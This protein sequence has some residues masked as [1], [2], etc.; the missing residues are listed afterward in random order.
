MEPSRDDSAPIFVRGFSRS[1]GTLVVTL[2]DAHP[3]IAMSYELYPNL[4]DAEEE[5]LDAGSIARA[6]GRSK[7][8]RDAAKRM[9]T[10]GLR[11]FVT[12][13]A[14]GGLDPSSLSQLL[15]RHRDEG[16]G[17][18]TVEEQLRLIELCCRWKMEIAGKSR[19]GLKCNNRYEEYLRVWPDAF[20][21]NVVRDGRDVLSSQLKTGSFDNSPAAV[22]QGWS[23][24]HQRFKVL[25]ERPD[26][27]AREIRYERLVTEPESETEELCAFLGAPFDP[28][29]LEFHRRDLS[30]YRSHHLSMDRITKPIDSAKLGRW[31]SELT[32]AQV[33]EFLSTG[34]DMMRELGYL[35]G[36]TC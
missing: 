6:I 4:L 26:V 28:A 18:D 15:V 22:G 16:R 13:C 29:M 8:L 27:R 31:R 14:R 33:A 32:T 17:L 35:E 5:Q 25:M 20:F 36:E 1:G 24:T 11:T 19:W 12:R 10:N 7:S 9:P 34:G 21:L 3:E 2:L 23:N 30:I